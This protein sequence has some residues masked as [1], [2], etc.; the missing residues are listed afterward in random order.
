MSFLFFSCEKEKITHNG[1]TTPQTP[2]SYL[3]T[4]FANV[5]DVFYVNIYT[6]TQS[7]SLYS[8][9]NIGNS[10][11]WDYESIPLS[12]T[13]DTISL[14]DPLLSP[15]YVLFNNSNINIVKN[16]GTN[17]YLLKSDQYLKLTGT[18]INVYG[19]AVKDTLD[20]QL[21]TNKFPM[22][23]NSSF[24]DSGSVTIDT[25]MVYF[26]FPVNAIINVNYH[27]NSTIDASG[28]VKTPTGTY[29]C[30]R[31]KRTEITSTNVNVLGM[32]VY[33]TI[34]TVYKYNFW[35]KSKKWNVIEIVTDKNDKIKT[36][37]YLLN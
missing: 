12:S 25:Q 17:N 6:L 24:S 35:S 15:D 14:F 33:S 28:S 36:I 20:D 7:D 37:G 10:Q 30:V 5:G 16:D 4:D 29:A 8:I 11:K 3:S 32:S 9:G 22:T 1:D 19:I 2:Y 21:N 23:L 27:I 34:D 18:V 26:G 13:I 31:D